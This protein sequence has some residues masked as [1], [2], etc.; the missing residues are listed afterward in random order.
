MFGRKRPGNLGKISKI[1]VYI[2]V[3]GLGDLLFIIP[4]FRALKNRFPGAEVVF[5]GKLLQSY[6]R[7]VFDNCPYID[8]L[9]EYHFYDYVSLS[10]FASFVRSLRK[11]RFDILVDTQRKFTQSMLMS[12]GGARWMVSYSSGGVFS[13]FPVHVPDRKKRHTSDVSLDLARALGIENPATELEIHIPEENRAYAREFY[14]GHGIDNKTRL[15]GM[16]PAAGHPSRNWNPV[17]F[18]QLCDKLHAEDGCSI[19]YF[20]SKKD[21]PV[22]DECIVNMEAPAIV[23][24]FSRKSIL[25][26]AALM[27]RC[28]VIAGVDS[29]P[30]HVADATGAPCVGI[31]GPTLPERFGLLGPRTKEICLYRDCAPC[32]EETCGHRACLEDISALDVLDAARGLLGK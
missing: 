20:G 23:E 21:G 16:I 8:R 26:S 18:A 32:S 15:A 11:E 17:K 10:G 14:S 31:Y 3:P 22:I 27:Q 19:I 4:L 9:M 5:I 12:I 25:D 29:G 24:D 6:S 13:D 28:N 1:G 2:G 30:L 7:P